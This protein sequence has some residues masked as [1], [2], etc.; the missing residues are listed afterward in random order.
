MSDHDPY[1]APETDP[2]LNSSETETVPIVVLEHLRGTRPW[3][4]FC[5]ITGFV[6]SFFLIVIAIT[7]LR[8]TPTQ[9]TSF[10]TYLVG[11]FYITLALLFTIPS[12]RL[13]HYEKS[14]TRLTMTHHMEDLEIAISHQRAFWKQMALM[15]FL[16]LLLYL[17]TITFSTISLIKS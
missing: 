16:I 10:Q 5:S 15:I 17:G 6:C 11:G 1:E 3:V 12:I 14:I 8:F 7:T 4:K 13:S 2:E 9:L